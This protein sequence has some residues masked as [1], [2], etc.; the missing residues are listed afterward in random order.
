MGFFLACHL[1]ECKT[2]Q[3]AHREGHAWADMA[4]L[5]RRHSI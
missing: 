2:A 5:C 1:V 3:A 4:I